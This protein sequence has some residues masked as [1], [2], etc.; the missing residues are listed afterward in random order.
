MKKRKKGGGLDF[1]FDFSALS[2]GAPDE[3]EQEPEQEEIPRLN[4]DPV[5]FDNAL[6]MVGQ[7]DYTRDYFALVSGRFV[8]GDFIEALCADKNLRPS[9]VYITTLGMNQDNIDSLVNLVE[10]LGCKKVN[11]LVSHYFAGTER[12]N[13]MPYI[14]KEFSGRPMDLAVL[15]SHCKIALILSR[16]GD[17]LISG[18]ANLSSSNNV[19][20]FIMMHD[21]VTIS[22]VKRKLDSIMERFKVY[23]GVSGEYTPGNNKNNTGNR[24]FDALKEEAACQV[25]AAGTV[26]EAVAVQRAAEASTATGETPTQRATI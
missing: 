18:S 19:E 15:Q 16:K 7:M 2:F 10:C 23:S 5:I 20:Q 1:S 9:A 22:F 4:T 14:Y 26:E 12:H 13:L 3:G 11:L 24:A 25:E 6:E 17:I 21:P 8:F